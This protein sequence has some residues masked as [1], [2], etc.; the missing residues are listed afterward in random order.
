MLRREV[1]ALTALTP[2]LV[3]VLS[4]SADVEESV[5]EGT[6][7]AHVEVVDASRSRVGLTPRAVERL[8]LQTAPVTASAATGHSGRARLA[9]PYAALLYTADGR[10]W[11]Y[12]VAPGHRYLRVP[13]TVDSVQGDR[14]LLVDGPPVGSQVVT[15]GAAELLGTELDVGH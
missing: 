8:G 9:V 6:E 15:V 1:L 7:A 11:S 10:T 13:L 14:A 2:A 5:A 4:S 3:M 12:S